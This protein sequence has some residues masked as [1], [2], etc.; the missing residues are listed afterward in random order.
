MSAPVA[1]LVRPRPR[2][3]VEI[4]EQNPHLRIVRDLT[5]QSRL[6]PAE[7]R[8]RYRAILALLAQYPDLSQA[9]LARYIGC[10]RSNVSRLVGDACA[11]FGVSLDQPVVDQFVAGQLV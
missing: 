3:S 10:S 7:A 8:A 5:K 1:Q 2:R 4:N 6:A 9:Q 11:A